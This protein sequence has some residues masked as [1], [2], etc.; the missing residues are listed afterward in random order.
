M[1]QKRRKV[2]QDGW[3]IKKAFPHFDLPLSF[4]DAKKK[5]T[6]PAYVAGKAFWPFIGFVDRKRRFNKK[7]EE[8]IVKTKER[9]LRYCSHHDG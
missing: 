8:V 6:D 5:V 2:R 7:N 4:D 1:T 3:Y 9:P